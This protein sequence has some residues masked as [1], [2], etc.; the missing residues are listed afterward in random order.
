LGGTVS[1][2]GNA[3]FGETL[4]VNTTALTPAGVSNLTYQWKRGTANIGTNAATYTTGVDDI[5]STITVTVTAAN[6]TGEVTSAPT[7]TVTKATQT[8]PAAPE[9]LSNTTTTITLIVIEGCEYRI[10]S[11]EWQTSTEFTGLT[12]D[13]EYEFEARKAETATHFA[14]PASTA[15][16]TTTVGI[17]DLILS[18]VTLY[19]NPCTDFVIIQNAAGADLKIVNMIGETIIHLNKLTDLEQ[20][21]MDKL[22]TGIYMFQLTKE[23]NVKTVRVVKH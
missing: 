12:P 22:S 7:A 21:P 1:I 3:V 17:N 15:T 13:T 19:P 18:N 9:M 5:G 14:S 8:A 11:G 4:T 2:D 23:S 20:I 16:F 10:G 6:C